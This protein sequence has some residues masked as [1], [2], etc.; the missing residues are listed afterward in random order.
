[1]KTRRHAYTLIEL[2][3]VIAIIAILVGLL[4]P[5]V[6]RVREAANRTACANNLKQ[7]GLACQMYHD[8]LTTFPSGYLYT[9]P[10]APPIGGGGGGGIFGGARHFDRPP[11]PP[12]VVPNDPG[13]GWAALLLPYIEQDT[14]AS[15]IN[16][17]LPVGSP[18][19]LTP[20]TT[21]LRLYTCPSDRLTGLFTVVS[22]GNKQ[23]ATAAT[24]SYAACFGA[25]G[26]MN[27]QPDVGNG[28]FFRN[29][30]IRVGEITD[31]TSN[32]M[33]IGERA[34]FFAQSPWAGVLSNGSCRTTP[35]APTFYSIVELAPCM[36]M[37]RIGNKPLGDQ[38]LEP[39][40]FF[41]GHLGL[42]QFVFADGA[43]HALPHATDPTLLQALATRAGSEPASP[44]DF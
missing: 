26:L 39:Y 22:D 29:S 8:Q 23:M 12:P 28:V 32:T 17:K 27:T 11:P 15:T 25:L 18:S 1:V 30:Q 35:G 9:P 41:S 20:R 13:W 31:G 24:N 3:V 33:L 5:A 10:L 16:Y 34:G 2:L 4:L 36:V 44:S 14:L 6:Q 43:V 21:E 19:M 42:V 7:M 40:D 38:Y 37:A